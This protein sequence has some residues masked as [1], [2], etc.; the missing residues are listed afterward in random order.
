LAHYLHAITAPLTLWRALANI[1]ASVTFT[2]MQF[3]PDPTVA[4]VQLCGP[5][6][7]HR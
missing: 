5:S 4:V 6:R 3:S 1:G 2:T 7:V